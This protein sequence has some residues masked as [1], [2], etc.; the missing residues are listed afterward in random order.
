MQNKPKIVK[1]MV[2][3]SYIWIITLYINGLMY[4]PKDIDWADENM[5]MCVLQ[6]T[7]S[8]YV[9]P[10]IICSYFILLD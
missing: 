2:I 1:K 8:F 4:Q 10:Q 5:Y 7:T 6:L 9:T 3:R